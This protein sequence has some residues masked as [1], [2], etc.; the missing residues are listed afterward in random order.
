MRCVLIGRLEVYHEPVN[1]FLRRKG[2]PPRKPRE[3]RL[4][5]VE[6]GGTQAAQL[7]LLIGLEIA[8]EPL[9]M[10]VPFE[11]ENMRGEPVQEEAVVADDYGAAGEILER[12]LEARQR[13]HVEIVRRLVEQDQIPALLQHLGQVHAVSLAA[14]KLPH[15]LLLVRPLEVEPAAIGAGVHLACA[16]KY[17][18]THPLRSLPASISLSAFPPAYRP[19]DLQLSCIEALKDFAKSHAIPPPCR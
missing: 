5:R 7:V 10:A 6:R 18:E 12:R 16:M 1:V 14:R 17:Q 8:L 3:F 9:D 11:C 15:L 2:L 19:D 4:G 13:L